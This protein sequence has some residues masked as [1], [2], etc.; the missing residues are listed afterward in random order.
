MNIEQERTEKNLG[1]SWEKKK[2]YIHKVTFK[3]Y[4]Q[5]ITVHNSRVYVPPG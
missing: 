1:R 3:L 4:R 5:P 2:F